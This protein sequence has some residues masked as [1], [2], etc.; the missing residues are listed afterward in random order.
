VTSLKVD[1]IDLYKGWEG[2]L[3]ITFM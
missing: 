3:A 2:H 1:V